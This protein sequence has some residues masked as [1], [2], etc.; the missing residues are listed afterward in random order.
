VIKSTG[1]VFLSYAAEDSSVASRIAE[2]LKAA[3]V[4]IW[5][6]KEA[7][8]GGDAWD[9]EIRE[10]ISACRLFIPVISA[11]TQARDEGYCRR[12][13]SIAVTRTSDIAEERP[14]LFPVVVDNI[15][16]R[17]ALVP[18]RF[19]DVQ[20][21]HLP[22]GKPTQSFV[23]TVS[24][25][26]GRKTSVA[27]IERG[28]SELVGRRG[29]NNQARA[30][31]SALQSAVTSTDS[32]RLTI[33]VSS[34][35]NLSGDPE[36]SIFCAGF[37]KD[38]ITELARWRLLEVR[39]R[40]ASLHDE[41]GFVIPIERLALR[42]NVRYVVDGSVRRLGDSVR[43][44][45]QLI[46]ANTEQQIW[47]EHYDRRA[48]E[49]FAVQDEVAQKVVSTLVGRLRVND[50]SRVRRKHPSNLEAYE[51]VLKGNDL[52]WD[53]PVKATEA[54]R[55]FKK[56]IQLDPEYGIAYGL[57]ANMRIKEMRRSG[58]STEFLDEAYRLARRAVELDDGDSS[59]QSLLAVVHLFRREFELALQHIRRAVELNPNNQWNLANMAYVLGYSGEAE[60][61]L[62]WSER[63]KHADPYFDTPWF[64]RQQARSY[65]ILGR[66]QEALTMLERIPRRTHY[67]SAY[68]AACHA[69]L[70]NENGARNLA[71]ECLARRPS[72][73]IRSLLAAEPFKVSSDANNLVRSLRLAGLPE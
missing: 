26:L 37:S 44:T 23:S 69:S 8:Q 63:A 20:W 11:N 61:A 62:K 71:A 31:S 32:T 27:A 18:D 19:R 35:E 65:M 36:Q 6:D 50:A 58:D 28:V 25:L 73:T 57:L 16:T 47:G 67:D 10:Q 49:I 21:T 54:R 34:F 48:A 29:V 52:S 2:A 24:A 4:M 70:G 38:I 1:T 60:Q 66:Y 39:P 12:E 7:L 22:D 13:W 14:F 43:I 15:P 64:W 68:T 41:H 42:S 46:D 51:C 59:C 72:F 45:V 56:A 30:V 5:L 9:R 17:A 53:D 40:L 55:L 33:C 3:G